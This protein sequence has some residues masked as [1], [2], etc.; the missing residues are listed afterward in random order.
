MSDNSYDVQSEHRQQATKD[1]IEKIL[2]WFNDPN[3]IHALIHELSFTDWYVLCQGQSNV[4]Q[5]NNF[6][7]KLPIWCWRCRKKCMLDEWDFIEEPKFGFYCLECI[8]EIKKDFTRT[9]SYCDMNCYMEKKDQIVALCP[10]CKNRP[11]GEFLKDEIGRLRSQLKR[12]ISEGVPT[13]LT[14]QQWVSTINHFDG[15]C[16]YCQ[17]KPFAVMEHFMPIKLGGG[18]TFDNCVPACTR[19]NLVKDRLASQQQMTE[20]ASVPMEHVREFLES[21]K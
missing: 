21:L 18:T 20:F 9:C 8:K 11:D 19:C 7:L 14:L 15:L 3:D 13:T 6:F 12:A 5:F 16:A 1:I 17:S 2:D 10:D 4:D